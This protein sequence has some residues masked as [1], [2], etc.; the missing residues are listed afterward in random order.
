VYTV[1]RSR[2]LRMAQSPEQIWDRAMPALRSPVKRSVWVINECSAA[3]RPGQLA[4]LSALARHS[5]L[6]EPKWPVY[7]LS[8]ADWKAATDAGVRE[9]PEPVA[10][11]QEW[12]LWRYSPALIPDAAMVDPLSLM[13][14]LKD[15]P[16]D[17]VQLA[18]GELKRTLPW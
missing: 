18:L 6:I 7:A 3:K 14:S 11:A 15:D 4:G 10:G 1:S 13:L 2:W 9:I 8:A 17:R 16:D 12:Q 5:M